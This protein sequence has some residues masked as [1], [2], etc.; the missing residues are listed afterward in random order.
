MRALT[1]TSRITGRPRAGPR[2]ARRSRGRRS[3]PG[4]SA[5]PSRRSAASKPRGR[6]APP[7]RARPRRR[8][9]PPRPP[10]RAAPPSAPRLRAIERVGDRGEQRE[11]RLDGRRARPEPGGER[12]AQRRKSDVERDREA[13]RVLGGDR[14]APGG[15]RHRLAQR[16]RRR[17]AD[18]VLDGLVE[19]ARAGRADRRVGGARVVERRGRRAPPRRAAQ[20]RRPVADQGRA[21]ER[22]EQQRDAEIR[23]ASGD[24]A[25]RPDGREDGVADAALA[26]R[27]RAR[28]RSRSR[29]AA[30]PRRTCRRSRGGA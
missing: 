6:R 10:T 5:L 25:R 18:V 29:S 3:S 12:A 14:V 23:V 24:A 22:R 21:G 15:E 19:A 11:E 13:G 7:R 4:C 27:A 26:R 20:Q 16:D 9:P 8:G 1:D 28:G 30:C 17:V 2:T